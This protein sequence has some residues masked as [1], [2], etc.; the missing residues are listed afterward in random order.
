MTAYCAMIAAAS[1]SQRRWFSV[2]GYSGCLK[3]DP[4]LGHVASGERA[5]GMSSHVLVIENDAG[6]AMA[7]R[8]LLQIEGHTV[9]I[10][11]NGKSGLRMAIEG[12]FDLVVLELRLPELNGLAVCQ[13][14]RERGFIGAIL[15]LTAKGHVEDRV[16]GLRR[17]AD[18]CIIKP[19]SPVELVARAEAL[20]RRVDKIW[21]TPLLSYRFGN[22]VADFLRLKLHKNGTLVSLTAKEWELLRFLVNHRGE[23]V[24]RET[25]LAAVWAHRKFTTARTVDVHITWLRHK[26]EDDPKSPEH[27]LTVRGEGY[28]FIA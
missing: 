6:L 21:L 12:Q 3:D 4:G 26:L 8:K 28:R 20:L 19:F 15:L 5:F 17:G 25:I 10:A 9:E 11:D 14:I 13:T 24:S 23:V 22:I 16:E 18:D 2:L 27:I 1:K 7:V